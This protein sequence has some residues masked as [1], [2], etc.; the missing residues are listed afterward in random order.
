MLKLYIFSHTL[1]Q[2]AYMFR[3]ILDRLQGFF[4]TINH[5]QEANQ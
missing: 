4:Y 1:H 5:V 2:N 3:S